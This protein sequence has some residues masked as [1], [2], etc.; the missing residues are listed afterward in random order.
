[1]L[2]EIK[3]LRRPQLLGSMIALLPAFVKIL[4]CSM[5]VGVLLLEFLT[6]FLG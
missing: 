4:D 2:M 6:D 1:M 5:E 3:F